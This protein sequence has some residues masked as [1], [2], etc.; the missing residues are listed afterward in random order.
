[1]SIEQGAKLFIAFVTEQLAQL[2]PVRL[3]YRANFAKLAPH[4]LQ[5]VTR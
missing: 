3:L 1:M 5:S 2:I 4:F